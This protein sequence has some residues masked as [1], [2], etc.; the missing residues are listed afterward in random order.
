MK[1]V[2]EILDYRNALRTEIE[3]ATS[4]EEQLALREQVFTLDIAIGLFDNGIQKDRE[5]IIS[6]LK[7]AEVE[8]ELAEC[9]HYKNRNIATVTAYMW[10]LSSPALV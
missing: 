10:I 5:Q 1:T 8:A 2:E 3:N 7:D 9:N 6:L 4:D